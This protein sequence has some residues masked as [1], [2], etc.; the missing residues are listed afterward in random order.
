MYRPGAK[1]FGRNRVPRIRI[2][3]TIRPS[4][5]DLSARLFTSDD[6]GFG[7]VF[8]YQD[9]ENYFRVGMRQQTS[10]SLG[11]TRGLAVQKVV[12]GDITQLAGPG[13]DAVP[14][15][16]MI[17]GRLPIDVSVSV[18]GGAWA[19]S[20]D[21]F[22]ELAA[23]NDDDLEPG[24]IGVHSWAERA[25]SGNVPIWGYEVDNVSLATGA[26]TTDYSFAGPMQWRALTMTNSD[27]GV[28]DDPALDLRAK[29]NAGSRLGNFGLNFVN[30]EIVDNTNGYAIATTTTP[31]VDFMGPA[32][33]VD[34]PGTDSLGD[35]EMKVRLTNLDD[36]GIG[37]LVRAQ[38]DNNFYRVVFARELMF[39]TGSWQEHERAPRGLSVQKVKDGEWSELF[40]DD[41]DNPLF[42][43]TDRVGGDTPHDEIPFD[44][45]VRAVGNQI[46]VQ[47]IDDPDGAANVITYPILTDDDPILT[48]TVG[49]ANWGSGGIGNH[50]IWSS[51]GGETG[52]LVVEMDLIPEP[53]TLALLVLG[54]GGLTLRRRR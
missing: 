25:D 47:V 37:V 6:D 22:G 17:D 7:V 54:L 24:K 53:A 16:G 28:F 39:G 46:R 30:R 21:G 23:G 20:V 18:N 3:Y 42:V 41:Q 19:V 38:D 11:F 2:V 10:G 40:R 49:L 33:V 52:P 29:S 45:I 8:G 15:Q 44:L 1:T 43:F 36:D 12:G 9:E 50:V 34:E 5:Y 31:N 32:V 14:T 35:Y 27:G 4:A 13:I 26:G 51:F 48:G